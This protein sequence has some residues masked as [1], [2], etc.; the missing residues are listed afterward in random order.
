MIY[1]HQIIIVLPFPLYMRIHILS[2]S[3]SISFC[4]P[5]FRLLTKPNK[6]PLIAE[7][8]TAVCAR[9]SANMIGKLLNKLSMTF[10]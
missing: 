7:P 3:L 2:V 8:K 4:Y 10:L 1:H 6:P 5:I 9:F